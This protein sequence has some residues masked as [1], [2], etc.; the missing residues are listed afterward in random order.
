MTHQTD[1]KRVR[2][3]TR[4]PRPSARR[5]GAGRTTP[6]RGHSSCGD[7]RQPLLQVVADYT[8]LNAVQSAGCAGRG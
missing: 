1:L 2:P 6:P 3:S 8:R 7:G 5:A 4:L